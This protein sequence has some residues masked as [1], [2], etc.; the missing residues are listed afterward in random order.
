MEQLYSFKELVNM[1]ID[2]GTF[3]LYY[4]PELGTIL[5]ELEWGEDGRLIDGKYY[6]KC[7]LSNLLKDKHYSELVNLE[8]NLANFVED[9]YIQYIN[10]AMDYLV[11]E[12]NCDKV[13]KLVSGF[14]NRPD[15]VIHST[16]DKIVSSYIIKRKEKYPELYLEV[17][18]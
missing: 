16:I 18:L 7:N 1:W 10:C 13:L 6:P 5:F 2:N 3:G 12:I 15:T 14:K 9:K 4:A 17:M 8:A 11:Q